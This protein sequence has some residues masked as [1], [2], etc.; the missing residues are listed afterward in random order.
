[1]TAKHNYKLTDSQF[2]EAYRASE[3]NYSQTAKY[4]REHFNIPYTKQ[5]AQER[6]MNHPEEIEQLLS[7]MDNESLTTI[8]NFADDI[9]LDIKLRARMYV[10]VM[11][12]INQ[13]ERLKIQV[14]K[15]KQPVKAVPEGV[16]QFGDYILRFP[17]RG[18]PQLTPEE[19]KKKR[20]EILE[21]INREF[22]KQNPQPDAPTQNHDNE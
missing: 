2:I 6:A 5:S 14:A 22:A 16:F 19:A 1:M 8:M 7:I 18:D 20:L 10:Q 11:H 17:K 12:K 21:N 13:R 15:A 3:G 4:I 9:T